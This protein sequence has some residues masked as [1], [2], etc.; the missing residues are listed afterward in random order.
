MRR[1]LFLAVAATL[2]FTATASPAQMSPCGDATIEYKGAIQALS[3]SLGVYAQ[4]LNAS[5]GRDDCR[6]QF[7]TVQQDQTRLESIIETLRAEC[8]R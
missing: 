2:A 8:R 3:Q 7:Q 1:G 6:I 4:C 5:A